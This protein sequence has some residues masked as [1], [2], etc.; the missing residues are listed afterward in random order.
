MCTHTYTPTVNA[1]LLPL[2]LRPSRSTVPAAAAEAEEGAA[3]IR[4]FICFAIFAALSARSS[5][6][7]TDAPLSNESPSAALSA[8][9]T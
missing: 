8:L 6:D 4:F 7:D 3:R 9:S 5:T 2:L 1:A